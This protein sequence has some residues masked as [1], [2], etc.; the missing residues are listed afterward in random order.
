MA[1]TRCAKIRSFGRNLFAALQRQDDFARAD[2]CRQRWITA[3]PKPWRT[4][5]YCR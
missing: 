1:P 2:S 4:S 3:S 5:A